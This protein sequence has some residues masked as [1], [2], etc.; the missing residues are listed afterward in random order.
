MSRGV[1]AIDGATMLGWSFGPLMARPLTQLEA[2]TLK[3]PKPLSGVHRIAPPGTD[4]GP[5]LHAY[6]IWLE[7]MF[8]THRP[9]GLIFEAPIIPRKT[10]PITV[11][12]LAGIAGIAQMVAHEHGL[13]WVREVSPT[14]VKLHICGDGT[15]G[16][17]GVMRAIAERGWTFET[18]DVA[19]ALALWDL[20]GHIYYRE[21]QLG[22]RAA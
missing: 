19:D 13:M 9:A 20:A 21:R 5:F 8:A 18:D 14:Q 16:K 10:T 15:G 4:I 17:A 12:K 22:Q 6:R 1:L 2:A 7:G 11:R 3:P